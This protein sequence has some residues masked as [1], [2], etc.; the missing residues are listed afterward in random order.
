MF[1][2]RYNGVA[3][4]ARTGEIDSNSLGTGR[5]FM[6]YDRGTVSLNQTKQQV[7]KCGVGGTQVKFW[8]FY[9]VKTTNTNLIDVSDCN[10]TS[11]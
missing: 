4:S 3:G 5:P 9:H 7:N 2:K 11:S 8:P 10:N 1:P 6:A